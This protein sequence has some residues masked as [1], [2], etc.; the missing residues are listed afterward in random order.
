MVDDG[1]QLK[2][3]EIGPMKVKMLVTATRKTT[4]DRFAAQLSKV[5]C[6][7]RVQKGKIRDKLE[8]KQFEM[9]IDHSCYSG[10]I[11]KPE[12]EEGEEGEGEEGATGSKDNGKGKGKG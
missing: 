11:E 8:L 7:Q 12:G 4:Q 9:N 10:D 5:G 6:I 3:I 2:S 1:L